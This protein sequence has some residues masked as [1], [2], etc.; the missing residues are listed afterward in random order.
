MS[1]D[2]HRR[3]L[4]IALAAVGV[5]GV[6][7]WW[8]LGDTGTPDTEL[9]E[10]VTFG[11]GAIPEGSARDGEDSVGGRVPDMGPGAAPRERPEQ[12]SGLEVYL[13]ESVYP[14][15]SRP[16]THESH[17]DII[18]WNLRAEYARPT[19][20]DPTVTFLYSADRY[21]VIGSEQPVESF[22]DVRRGGTALRPRIVR[23][24]A[25]VRADRGPPLATAPQPIELAYT[26]NGERMEHS[27]DPAAFGPIERTVRIRMD[28]QFGFEGG[29]TQRDHIN[30]T[31]TPTTAQPARFTGAFREEVEEGSLVLYAGVE[32]VQA[33]WYNID[34]N[35]WDAEDEPV[36]WSRYKGGLEPTDTEV[37]LPFF[38]KV[39]RD[40]GST[41]PWHIGELRGARYLEESSPGEQMMVPFDGTYTTRAYELETFSE[42]PY[43]DPRRDLIVEALRE[44]AASGMGVSTPAVS[45]ETAPEPALRT[46]TPED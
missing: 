22:L 11:V 26:W 32:V 29:G 1:A 44:E 2:T 10:D 36:A 20:S 7:L 8:V 24:T 31:Y 28:I 4:W 42:E 40:S 38:G 23:A 18:D 39:L 13:R 33:G 12:L 17:S 46:P 15:T 3:R 6:L 16:L 43:D 5:G 21:F 37:R 35:L 9:V 27:L 41:P 34:C 45:F 19:Q 30:F 25:E 14:P